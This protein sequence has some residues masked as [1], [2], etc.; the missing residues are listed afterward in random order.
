MTGGRFRFGLSSPELRTGVA[1]LALLLIN[2][3]ITPHFVQ[4]EVR[5][6]RLFGALIDILRNGSIVVLLA[7][8]MCLVIAT[9]GI[10]LSVGSVMALAGAVAALAL[11]EWGLSSPAALAL[12]VLTGVCAGLF[13]GALVTFLRLQPIVATLVLLVAGRGLAQVLTGDQKVRFASPL[14]EQIA[15][16]SLAGLPMPAFVA[17]AVALLALLLVRFTAAGMYIHAIGD[18]PRAAMLCG[19][20]VHRVRLLVYAAS[21]LCAGAAGLIAAAEIREA[22]VASAGLYHELD[23]ILAVVIG[24]T[25]LTGGRPRVIGAVL[26]AL[27]IQTLTVM[28]QMRGIATEHGLV[29]KAGVALAVC[30][31]QA[32]G[33]FPGRLRRGGGVS[34]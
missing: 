34:P 27:L 2:A 12:G 3:I 14:F 11:V 19:L 6:G 24:G 16:G 22:D 18:N 7:T 5:D 1:L 4:V 31:P 20:P 17:G 10:D 23:A 33:F 21:G 26:G 29:L 30:L 8:G 13:N 15:S 28:L 25:A 32:P 9:G